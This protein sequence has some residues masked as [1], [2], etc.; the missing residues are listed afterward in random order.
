VNFPQECLAVPVSGPPEK[1]P[2]LPQRPPGETHRYNPI[3]E[4]GGL[5][6]V[7]GYHKEGSRR[8]T[9]DSKEQVLKLFASEGVET[10]EGLVEKQKFAAG[11]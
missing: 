2:A 10:P 1:H 5:P 3:C 8:L 4:I 9:S 7:V 11:S 6:E